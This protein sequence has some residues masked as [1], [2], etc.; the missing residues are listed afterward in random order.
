MKVV[1]WK[2]SVIIIDV[3]CYHCQFSSLPLIQGFGFWGFNSYCW[4]W[5]RSLN[6]SHS[7]CYGPHAETSSYETIQEKCVQ[8]LIWYQ[9]DITNSGFKYLDPARNILVEVFVEISFVMINVCIQADQTPAY[10]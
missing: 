4:C 8:E 7:K 1:D 5:Y 3:V 6:P 9:Y 2:C 10:T